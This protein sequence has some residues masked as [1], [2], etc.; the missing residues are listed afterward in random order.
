MNTKELQKSGTLSA[1]ELCN[2]QRRCVS[3]FFSV[4]QSFLF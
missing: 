1:A 4:Q 3:G 2:V